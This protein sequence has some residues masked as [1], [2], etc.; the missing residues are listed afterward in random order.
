AT[1]AAEQRL[2]D[3]DAEGAATLAT[4]ALRVS[5]ISAISLRVLGL[6]QQKLGNWQAGNALMGQAAALGWRDL[7]TQLWL[8]A[9]SLQTKDYDGAANRIDGAMRVNPDAPEL[10]QLL[11]KMLIDEKLRHALVTRLQL[12]PAWRLSY[13]SD[14]TVAAPDDALARAALLSDL[15]GTPNP[16]QQ[17]ELGTVL[18]LMTDAG[19]ADQ[20]RA[21]WMTAN[22]AGPAPLYDGRFQHTDRDHPAIFQ[23]ALMSIPGTQVE[24]VPHGKQPGLVLHVTT[25]ASSA[26]ILARQWLVLKPGAY[27]LSVTSDGSPAAL[28]SFQWMIRCVPQS[29]TP[30]TLT[31]SGKR[32]TVG[33]DIPEKGCDRQSLELHAQPRAASANSEAWFSDMTLG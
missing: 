13:F 1:A 30:L 12:Q 4:S 10:H 3:G 19:H 6:S 29:V 2:N 11:D 23:W 26:G 25:D 28:Q 31:G 8:A 17:G 5:P 18:R 7:Q 16:P 20:A 22:H 27:H 15:V 32:D 24:A 9:A 21:L 33:F 14:D